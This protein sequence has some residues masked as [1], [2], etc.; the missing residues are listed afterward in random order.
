MLNHST[1][2]LQTRDHRI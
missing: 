2:K 1:A